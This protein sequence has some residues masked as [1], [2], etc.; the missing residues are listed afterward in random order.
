M[1]DRSIFVRLRADVSDYKRKI[2]EA[3]QQTTDFVS[4]NEQSVNT[5]SNTMGLL[6]AGLTGVAA[7]AVTKF[8]D[9]DS[10]MSSVQAATMESADNMGLLRQA[11]LDAG[12]RTVYSASEAAGAIEELAKAGVSTADVLDGGLNGSLD[13]AASGAIGV[14]EAAEIAASTMTQFGLAGDDVTHIADV[15]AA[16]A[17]KAQGSVLDMGLAMKYVGVPAAQLGVSLEETA[18][19]IALFASNGIIGEQAGTSLRSIIA[20]L[21]APSEAASKQMEE[22]GLSVFDA[23]GEFIGLAGVADQLQTRLG[24]LTE[25]ERANALGRIFGNESLQAANVLYASGAE[26]VREWTAAVDDQG[27]AAEQAAI[28][29]DNLRGDWEGFTGALDTAFI[30]LGEGANGPLR[31]LVQS[32]T[33]VV[34]AFSGLPDAVQGGTL[35]IVGG[36]GLALLGV[37]ALGKLVVGANEVVS[38]LRTMQISART[39]GLA[40]GAVGG[41]LTI[42]TIALTTWAEANARARARVE[43]LRGSLEETSGA[44]TT[45]TRKTLAEAATKDAE[46]FLWW[47]N[48]TVAE[49]AERLGLTVEDLTD[50]VLGNAGAMRTVRDA[51]AGFDGDLQALKGAADGAG[52]SMTEYGAAQQEVT[53]WVEEQRNALEKSRE[54]HGEISAAVDAGA[55]SQGG[56][57]EATLAATGEVQAQTTSLED[58]VSGLMTLTNIVLG[59]RD[60]ARG[61]EQAYDDATAAVEKNGATLDVTTEKGRANQAALDGIASAGLRVIDTMRQN[62]ATQDELQAQMQATRDRFIEVAQRMGMSADQASRLADELGLIPRKVGVVVD[63]ET[64]TAQGTLDAFLA[65]NR[66]RS[67]RINAIVDAGGNTGGGYAKGGY[68]GPG[69][70]Y[71]VAGVVHAD[72]HVIRSESRA[73][74]EAAAPGL[75]DAL[76]ARGAGAL[77][78]Y[79]VGGRVT[80]WSAGAYPRAFPTPA[81]MAPVVQVAAPTVGDVV[82]RMSPDDIRALGDYILAGSERVAAGTLAAD[83]R[84]AAGTRSTMGDV[85]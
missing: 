19:T 26:K 35:A 69:G 51:T 33:D 49:Q 16:A 4:K 76:N 20:S 81:V 72:E 15:L 32:G 11:A 71:D 39:A 36:G 3:S 17:G 77:R 62:G 78:G 83:K 58:L 27:F 5:L 56:L 55:E 7:I 1:A 65:R 43:E 45:M 13:L 28:R 74:I 44:I 67:V 75:L 14:A 21:T 40:V 8:A 54:E 82:A 31:Q 68:T 66:A 9:F 84:A 46:K 2:G 30:N 22:L 80:R 48:P 53:A 38:A 70:K 25:E 57:A 50:A 6:G 79:D 73:S 52:V 41:A 60:A 23:N 34:S 18:G 42:A 29:L 64:A 61:F 85:W 47:S 12:E 24:D 63:M 37:A 59:A 10:A